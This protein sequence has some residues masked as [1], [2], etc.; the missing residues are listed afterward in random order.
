MRPL[1]GHFSHCPS[2]IAPLLLKAQKAAQTRPGQLN[3]QSIIITNNC[4]LIAGHKAAL[5]VTSAV[6]L[7][8]DAI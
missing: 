1:I 2:F 6:C 5:P 7:P 3:N 4:P 8:P